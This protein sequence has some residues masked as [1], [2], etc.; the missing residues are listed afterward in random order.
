MLLKTSAARRF[1]INVLI[2]RTMYYRIKALPAVMWKFFKTNWFAIALVLLLLVAVGRN[3]PRFRFWNAGSTTVTSEKYTDVSTS[4]AAHLDLFGGGGS[5]EVSMPS[6]DDATAVAFLK[7]FGN[8]SVNER[9]KFGIPP[10]VLLACAYV[11][12]HSGQ[13][14]AALQANN[15][16]ALP[17]PGWDGAVA[18][19]DGQCFRRYDTAWASF[20]DFGT[21]VSRQSWFSDVR[22]SAGNDWQEWLKKLDGKSISDVRNN[23]SEMHTVIETYRLYELDGQ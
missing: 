12:S 8:L 19:L 7:R 6:I 4:T 17:C 16:F 9:K 2:L 20:R 5:A 3:N 1:L 23:T 15:F 10:S 18:T 21:F 13:R 22:K 14:I 11:N